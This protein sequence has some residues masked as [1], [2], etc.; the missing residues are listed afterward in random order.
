MFHFKDA[1]VKHVMDGMAMLGKISIDGDMSKV[2]IKQ[3]FL[4]SSAYERSTEAGKPCTVLMGT[5]FE[6]KPLRPFVS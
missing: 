6:V 2:N 1:S 3:K 4:K 5:P